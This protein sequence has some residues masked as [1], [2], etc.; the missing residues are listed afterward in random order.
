[1][2][3]KTILSNLLYKQ[4][5]VWVLFI[6][7]ALPRLGAAFYSSL[8]VFVP[9]LYLGITLALWFHPQ[10][11]IYG[12]RPPTSVFLSLV[13]LVG[14]IGIYFATSTTLLYLFGT[15]EHHWNVKFYEIMAETSGATGGSIFFIVGASVLC[16]YALEEFYFRGL[17]FTNLKE[18]MGTA[19]T[20]VVIAVLWSLLHLGV[21]GL[22]PFDKFQI[23]G[24]LPCVILMGIGLG[25]IRVVT[26]S[27]Y[28][29]FICQASANIFL[30]WWSQWNFSS[31]F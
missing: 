16:I 4:E 11:Y 28:V 5:N 6:L 26:G 1:M 27:V 19:M 17:L 10:R 24:M 21:Y 18:K 25:W 14:M 13:G 7:L 20:I 3:I 8:N 31:L 2:N 30:L 23:A 15:S 29:C 9:I 22:Q 12:L